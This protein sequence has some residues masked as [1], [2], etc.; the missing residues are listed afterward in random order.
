MFVSNKKGSGEWWCVRNKKEG[1]G[2]SVTKRR[3]VVVCM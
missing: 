1:C 3:V 2:V